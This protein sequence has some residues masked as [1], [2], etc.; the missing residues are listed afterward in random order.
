MMVCAFDAQQVGPRTGN[1]DDMRKRL[2]ILSL[3][4]QLGGCNVQ[5]DTPQNRLVTAGTIGGAG[6]AIIGVMVG[7]PAYGAVLGGVG[8]TAF[9][10][11]LNS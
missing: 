3:A 9:S 4:I 1:G 5:L 2:I 6:G 7:M 10:A 8:A 11:W